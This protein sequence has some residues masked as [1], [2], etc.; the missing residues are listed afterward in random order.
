MR[1]CELSGLLPDVA[2][3]DKTV[4][5]YDNLIKTKSFER[6]TILRSAMPRPTAA[7]TVPPPYPRYLAV[8]ILLCMGCAF[9]ATCLPAIA[10][11]MHNR[12]ITA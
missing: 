12:M 11:P 8:I 3:C 5:L 1:S 6:L 2:E 9:A 10:Q 4:W 7:Q